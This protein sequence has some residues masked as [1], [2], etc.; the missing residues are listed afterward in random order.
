MNTQTITWTALPNG[1]TAYRGISKLKLSVFASPR[2]QT[3]KTPPTLS[4]FPDFMDWPGTLSPSAAGRG[5]LFYVQFGTGEPV[6]ATQTS[7][8]PKSDLWKALFSDTTWVEPYEFTDYKARPIQSY[9]VRNILSFLKQQY[10][11]LATS[12]GEEFP[13]SD[14]L[15]KDKGAPF[16]PLAFSLRE[17][18]EEQL[19]TEIMQELDR[20]KFNLHVNI[21]STE[22]LAKSF[23]EAKLFHKPFTTDMIK[24]LPPSIDF[25]RMTSLLGDYPVLLRSMGLVFDLEVPMPKT[26]NNTVQVFARWTSRDQSVTTVNIPNDDQRFETRC[27]IGTDSFYALSSAKDPEIADGMLPFENKE[28]YE[29]VQIDA[30]GAALKTLSFANNL[31]IARLLRKTDDTPETS[32]VPSLRSGGFSVVRVNSAEKTHESFVRQDL[33]NQNLESN[34]DTILDAEDITCGFVID[35]WDSLTQQ[36][37]SLCQRV[38][39]YEFTKPDPAIMEKEEDEGWVSAGLTSAADDSSDIFRQGESV[40]RWWGW[41]L[42]APR[43]GKTLDAD[44]KPVSPEPELDPDY[45]LSVHFQ[46][47]PASLPRLRYG[48]TYRLRARAVDL[49]GNR[50]ALD[51]KSLSGDMHATEPLIY[52]R[53][54]PVPPPVVVM[55]NKR[56]EGESVE[57]LVIRSNYNE[58]IEVVNE[59]HIVPPKSSQTMAEEHQLFDSADSGQVDASAYDLI[60][61]KEYGIIEGTP[62]PDNY[63]SPYVDEDNLKLPY[64]PDVF[65]R[66][67]VLRGI[68]NISGPYI[69]DF[70][71][72]SISKWPYGLPFRLVFGESTT[73]KVDFDDENRIL[74][75]LLPKA[76]VAKVRLSSRM[77]KDDAMQMGLVNWI[78]ES[79]QDA[80]YA[81]KLADEGCHWMLEP[82]RILTLVHAV[83]QPLLT[84]EFSDQ[85]GMTRSVGDTFAN[86][87]DRMF[88]VNRKSTSKLDIIAT[89]NETLDPLGEIA[90]RMISGKAR[91]FV[92]PVPL[93]SD[94]E[95]EEILYVHGQHEFGDTKYRSVT[96]SAIATTRF[97]EYYLQRNRSVQLSGTDIYTLDSK[98]IVESSEAVRL[99]DN[100]ANYKRYDSTHKMGDYVVDYVKGTIRR[101]NALE[102]GS[103]I[104]ENIKLEITYLVPPITRETTQPKTLDILS[105]ARPAVPRVLY[106][107]PTFT[108]KTPTFGRGISSQR[109]GGGIRIYLERPWF[110]S[111]DGELL[112]VIIWPNSKDTSL[113]MQPPPEKVKSYVTQWGLDPVFKSKATDPCPTLAAFTLS[114]SEYQASGL[115]L[116]EVP[117]EEVQ[118]NV[119]GHEVAYD[120]D[121]NLWYCD[122]NIDA[123]QSYFP[124][125][126]LA[127]ARY[128]PRSLSAAITGP[129]TFVH[130]GAANVHLSRVVLADFIQL[131]P[132]RYASVTRD[133]ANQLLRH[134]SV[135]GRSYQV[136]NGESGPGR[137][138][139]S[140]EQQRS[141]ITPEIAGELVWEPVASDTI[142]LGYKSN[143]DGTTT[144]TGDITLPNEIDTF[145]LL[146]KEFEIYNEPATVPIVRRRLVYADA[147]ILAP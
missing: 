21:D 135:T 24:I 132:D 8:S 50:L 106:V 59:R 67:A 72:D 27:Y 144:W 139:V 146:I 86:L 32:S 115:V 26:G 119:A 23:L 63:N 2:L 33:L 70:G 47:K 117:D 35:V 81:L 145:R 92:F 83:R 124:F 75:I 22:G 90:P 121:R 9:P 116:E 110:T 43:P 58:D 28:R 31:G 6:L 53:F 100:T 97:G 101:T 93:A 109:I 69:V 30:D 99:A 87:H 73:P 79:G 36:W 48:A 102:A 120:S 44:G 112:G 107:I 5:V 10:V 130:P 141:G 55:R 3:D 84:P 38:G 46:P 17:N 4:L 56:T 66:G 126:R 74:Q 125:V 42:S 13:S 147:I 82:Y 95:E 62:D 60:T 71:Y 19:T 85:L 49:A 129:E 65:S 122:I 57:R 136:L 88:Q 94:E 61:E 64:L 128:Q 15:I 68:P 1:V 123:G 78:I 37:H 134:V 11:S 20:N 29:V 7:D 98:G 103:A 114:K 96:Y 52:G 51:D 18:N 113:I 77:S 14:S 108:W 76:E 118:V 111:G 137:M 40:F 133:D 140:L 91:P 89:W 80:T 131:A 39:S 104:P 34:N 25:H 12:S 16:R 41:S 143:D 142:V 127:L 105:S 54:E 45:K 138:E